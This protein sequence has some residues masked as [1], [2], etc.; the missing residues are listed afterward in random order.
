MVHWVNV[1]V[2]ECVDPAGHVYA[3]GPAPALGGTLAECQAG[4]ARV[5]G[6][7]AGVNFG[8]GRIAALYHRSFTLYQIH[9]HIRCLCF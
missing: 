6:V 9:E 7:C 4:C 2:G 5:A 3:H 8:S 1:G